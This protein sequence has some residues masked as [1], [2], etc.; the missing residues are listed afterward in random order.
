[1]GLAVLAGF[2]P[3]AIGQVPGGNQAEQLQ[4]EAKLRELQQ[5]EL[6]T[7]MRA[8]SEIP[9]G[10]RYLLDVGAYV[11]F[12]YLSLDDS[13]GENHV[14]RQYEFLPY[15]RLSLDGAQELFLRG[16]FG[17]RDFNDGDSFDG[18]GDERIDGDLDRGFYKLDLRRYNAAY[19]T[20]V[21]G[22]SPTGEF[23]LVF[24]GGRDLVY[25]ANGLVM[26]Q[27][28]D[29]IIVD[30]SRPFGLPIDVQAIGGVTPVRTVD[31]DSSR[32]SFDHHTRRGFYGAMAST[33][34]GEGRHRPYVYGL[35]QRDYNEEDFQ[36]LGP[37]ETE[38][39][40]NSYYIGAGS[41]GAITDNL[42][43]GVEVAFEG[44]E[45]VS[46]SFVLSPAGG[47]FPIDQTRDDIH[48]MAFD[49]R[50]DYLFNNARQSRISFEFIGATGDND[51]LHT[52]NTF[53][54]NR[55]DTNDRSFNAFGLVNTGLAF[56]PE[57]SN[58]LCLRLGASTFPLRGSGLFRELQIGA[59]V[60]AFGK[61]EKNAPIDEPTFDHRY[62][63]WEPDIFVNWQITSDLTLAFRYGVFF[64]NSDAFPDPDPRHFIF[65]GLTFAF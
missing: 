21:L 65:A 53:G 11:Q 55:F 50:L 44:G 9:P 42:R 59:E 3:A 32:P 22:A 8:N 26:G 2:E 52:S 4:R 25:W 64:P 35:L 27:V 14:L 15:A 37:V 23:N 48:A 7:R 38:F 57:A 41:V 58:L 47:L 56:A 63:G 40:Y 61:F 31:F 33:T 18:R 51:R 60:F 34:V 39:E 5:L 1:M 62:L 36:S 16:R 10:Q 54:G 46:N 43:Y 49:F 13:L 29:G 12:T 6:D 30:V 17:W 45:T 20:N 24:Q 19:G 28:I